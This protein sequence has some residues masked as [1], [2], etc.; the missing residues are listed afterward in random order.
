MSLHFNILL[1]TIKLIYIKQKDIANIAISFCYI[2]ESLISFINVSMF[3]DINL[4][5]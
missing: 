1:S 5:L 4:S 3:F 2:F